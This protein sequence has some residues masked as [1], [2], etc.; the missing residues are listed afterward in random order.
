MKRLYVEDPVVLNDK[1]YELDSML[2]KFKITVL[3][4]PGFILSILCEEEKTVYLYCLFEDENVKYLSVIT[5]SKKWIHYVNTKL[6]KITTKTIRLLSKNEYPE[7]KEQLETAF[8][9][10]VKESVYRLEMLTEDV[11]IYGPHE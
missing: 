11:E 4:I 6:M 1:Q 10:F 7:Y 8:N 9:Y 3:D 5:Y 2:G